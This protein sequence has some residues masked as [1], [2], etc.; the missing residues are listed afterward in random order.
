MVCGK[1][2]EEN[3]EAARD[4]KLYPDSQRV[5]AEAALAFAQADDV[6]KTESLVDLNN[7]SPWTPDAITLVARDS[8]AAGAQQEKRKGGI[9]RLAGY[10]AAP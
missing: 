3:A 8:C 1:P 7:D 4:L 10:R 5:K 2:Q 6:A 9:D